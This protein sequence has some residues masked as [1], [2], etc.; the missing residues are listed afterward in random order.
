MTMVGWRMPIVA[1]MCR[2]HEARMIPVE[3]EFFVPSATA[4]HINTLAMAYA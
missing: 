4:E 2:E 1:R 3:R